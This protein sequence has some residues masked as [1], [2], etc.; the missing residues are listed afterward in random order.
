MNI[1]LVKK[2]FTKQNVCCLSKSALNNFILL[3]F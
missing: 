2:D 3:C 1:S